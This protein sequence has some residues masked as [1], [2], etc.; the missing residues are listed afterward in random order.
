MSDKHLDT[1]RT[2][3]PAAWTG[4]LLWIATKLGLNIS[5]DQLMIAAPIVLT[6]LYRIGKE[7]EAKWP[8]LGR[9][10]FGTN[11]KPSF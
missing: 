5:V 9:I 4:A 10:L 11:Q 2:T 6:I 7:V 8:A 1:I 3:V